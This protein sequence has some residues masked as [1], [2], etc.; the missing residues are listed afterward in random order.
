LNKVF[1]LPLNTKI[2]T[3]ILDTSTKQIMITNFY[4][5]KYFVRH[6]PKSFTN[7][8]WKNFDKY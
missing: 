2:I 5:E 6:L 8:S 3:S 1:Q 7:I 4:K